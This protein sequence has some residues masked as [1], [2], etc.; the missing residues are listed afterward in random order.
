M[1][2]KVFPE[3]RAVHKIM[4]EKCDTAKQATD[5]NIIRLT[6]N[7]RWISKAIDTF[8]EY[9]NVYCFSTATLVT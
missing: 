4:W 7:E 3:N 5:C 9:V 1:F 6:H 2:N 8:P